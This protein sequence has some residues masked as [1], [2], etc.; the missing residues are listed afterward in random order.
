[1]KAKKY[2]NKFL[3]SSWPLRR[4]GAYTFRHLTYHTVSPQ[5]MHIFVA[6]Q[7]VAC[8]YVAIQ[9][10]YSNNNNNVLNI[11]IS[12][13]IIC[14]TL[15]SIHIIYTCAYNNTIC[16]YVLFIMTSLCSLW[17]LLIMFGYYCYCCSIDWIF[18]CLRVLNSIRAY[19]YIYVY[20]ATSDNVLSLYVWW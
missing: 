20:N 17:I 15:N 4:N 8:A 5:L 10:Y 18:M 1:M 2:C 3:F 19:M 13:Y 9:F 7:C 14:H 16:F 11:C 12:R 6:S